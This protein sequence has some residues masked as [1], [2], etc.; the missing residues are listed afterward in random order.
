V[1]RVSNGSAFFVAEFSSLPNVLCSFETFQLTCHPQENL[2]AQNLLH[3]T[4]AN[5]DRRSKGRAIADPAFIF[6]IVY[7]Y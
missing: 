6:K 3:I 1:G 4:S 2:F 5:H 7:G